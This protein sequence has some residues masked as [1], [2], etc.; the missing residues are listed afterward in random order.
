MCQWIHA[1]LKSDCG[2]FRMFAAPCL[3]RC[4]DFYRLI[5]Y[6]HCKNEIGNDGEQYYRKVQ[7]SCQDC[8]KAKDNKKE[9]EKLETKYLKRIQSTTTNQRENNARLLAVLDQ[10]MAMD[11]EKELEK[12]AMDIMERTLSV[13]TNEDETN[14]RLEEAEHNLELAKITLSAKESHAKT[15]AVYDALKGVKSDSEREERKIAEMKD[16]I[17]ELT[18]DIEL[19]KLDNEINARIRFQRSLGSVGIT[20]STKHLATKVQTLS[21]AVKDMIIEDE[22]MEQESGS[23]FGELI[24]PPPS[25]LNRMLNRTGAEWW[26]ETRHDVAPSRP[27]ICRRVRR[28]CLFSP[29]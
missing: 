23:E 29:Y 4:P 21:E 20:R 27:V 12:L 17:E 2:H 25:L 8:V 10:L 3:V 13:T 9:L 15:Q 16:E 26:E 1:E 7:G 22:R 18:E 11:N 28:A 6:H 24:L 19:M 5:P 14:A